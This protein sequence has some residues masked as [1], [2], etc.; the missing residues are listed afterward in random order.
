L[1]PSAAGSLDQLDNV[2]SPR[3]SERQSGKSDALR[4]TAHY[5]FRELERLDEILDHLERERGNGVRSRNAH[6]TAIVP[7]M[8][9]REAGNTP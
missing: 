1:R 8:A 7:P 6:L 4:T 5:F 2:I 9:D 3:S